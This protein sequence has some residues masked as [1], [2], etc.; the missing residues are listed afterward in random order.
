MPIPLNDALNKPKNELG[1]DYRVALGCIGAGVCVAMFVHFCWARAGL[2]VAD[3]GSICASEGPAT[4][5][6]L[7]PVVPPERLL[8]SR[9]GTAMNPIRW[10]ESAGV[11][12]EL[13][14]LERFIDP[15]IFAT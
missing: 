10:F 14:S 4:L 13:V 9:E 11:S 5:P 12:S 2:R 6:A 8:R 7:V 1:L 15:Y 3:R